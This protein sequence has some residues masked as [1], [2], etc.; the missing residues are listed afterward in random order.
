M[1]R[2]SYEIVPPQA[3]AAGGRAAEDTLHAHAGGVY[4]ASGRVPGE[5]HFQSGAMDPASRS[6]KFR[7]AVVELRVRFLA[8]PTNDVRGA[9]VLTLWIP[10]SH[11]SG[12]AAT[13][14]TR[15]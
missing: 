6:V 8:R 12:C 10:S 13:P 14:A 9:E 4:R 1:Q 15:H 2:G 5:R 7:E 11:T 3:T